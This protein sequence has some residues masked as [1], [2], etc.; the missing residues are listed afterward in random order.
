MNDPAVTTP[1]AAGGSAGTTTAA[2][3]DKTSIRKIMVGIIL[4]MLLAAM[5]Q[6][7]VATAL[8]TIGNDLHDVEHLPWVVTAYL[9]SGTAVTPL[10]GK[11]ADVVG[12]RTTMMTSIFIF[13]AASVLSAIAPTMWFLIAA[14]FLQGLGGGGLIA[15]SQTIVGDVVPPVERMRYQGYFAIV[16]MTSSIAGPVL[17][18][19]FSD[20]LHWSLIF[21]I[22]LPLGALAFYMTNDVMKRLPR[23]ERP[24]KIDVIGAAL[25]IIA[26]VTVLLALSWGGGSYAWTSFQVIGLIVVSIVAWVLFVVRLRTAAE[27]FIP[28][29]VTTHPVVAAATAACFFAVGTM[30][31]LTIYLPLYF[32]VVMGMSASWSGVSLIAFIG[33]TV[34]GAQLASRVMAWTPHYKLGPVIG[35]AAAA[36]G[37]G[38]FAFVARSLSLWETEVLLA[39]IGTG[40]GTI[41]PITT[42]AVQN[43]VEPHELGTATAAFNFFRSLGSAFFVAVFGAVFIGSLGIGGQAIGSLEQL[44]QQAA[45][46]GTSVGPAF[47]YVFGA[48]A[49]TLAAGFLCMVAMEE[50]PLRTR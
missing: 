10:Y 24:H 35:L 4:A 44:I 2:R 32:E 3:L 13:V 46:Q 12:R 40:L 38:L 14:R 39:V 31:A 25:V 22:N 1:N 15:L 26:A 42:V 6:T 27:P 7:I 41:F 47:L 49:I 5:D 50:L 43:A 16:F 36:I 8:P 33:G 45:S 17:G 23:H 18:G 19:F 37:M 20:E 29:T 11:F 28:L 48:A 34:V 9:L 21:W 30:V